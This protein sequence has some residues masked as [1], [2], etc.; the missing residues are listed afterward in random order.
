[1]TRIGY[2]DRLE[3]FAGAALACGVVA[4]IYFVSFGLAPYVQ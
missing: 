4:G 1:M 2:T 3:F